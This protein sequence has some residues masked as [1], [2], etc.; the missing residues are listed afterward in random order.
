[1]SLGPGGNAAAYK[2]AAATRGDEI[3]PKLALD[4]RRPICYPPRLFSLIFS[5]HFL[6][7]VG[8]AALPP[9]CLHYV[10]VLLPG[11]HTGRLRSL[12][13][14]MSLTGSSQKT[15]TT[16]SPPRETMRLAQAS[17]R[18]KVGDVLE[19]RLP[20]DPAA[21]INGV[22]PVA[23]DGTIHLA[24][25]ARIVLAGKKLE[26]A[27]QA[28]RDALAIGYALQRFELTFHEYYMV[29]AS[30][31]QGAEGLA[32]GAEE[33]RDGQRCTRRAHRRWRTRTSGSPGP[34][35]KSRAQTACSRSI[36]T[37]SRTATKATLTTRSSPAITCLSPIDRAS[38]WTASCPV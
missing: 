38:S 12:I 20:D 19:F 22:Y 23:P 30:E 6:E 25:E 17:E 27:R 35:P 5:L 34:T 4:P 28:V 26:E 9:D 3:H 18:I 21:A 7:R 10:P 31:R 33:R 16:I 8:H 37:P 36:G 29:R 11:D 13:D 15:Q 32:R 2:S 24:G 14:T 1:M